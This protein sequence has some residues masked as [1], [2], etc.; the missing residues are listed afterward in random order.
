MDL[1]KGD[2]TLDALAHHVFAGMQR[3]IAKQRRELNRFTIEN[4]T[5]WRIVKNKNIEIE[6]LKK[7]KG[8]TSF[9]RCSDELPPVGG[10]GLWSGILFTNNDIR[11]VAFYDEVEGLGYWDGLYSGVVVIVD[12]T[13]YDCVY[14]C[15]YPK[16]HDDT[17]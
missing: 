7:R 8:F 14:W 2:G 12:P 15:D 1:I 13:E 9:T 4:R 10:D 6:E 5:L 17:K 3:K 16:F 11:L